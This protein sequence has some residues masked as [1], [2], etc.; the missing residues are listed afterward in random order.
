[1]PST[2]VRAADQKCA[3]CHA[4]IYH[5][6]LST[7]MANASGAAIDKLHAGAFLHKASGAQYQVAITGGAADLSYL[8]S[9]QPAHVDRR[10]LSYFLGSGHLGTTYLY[11]IGDYLFESP[12]AWYAASNSYDMKPGLAE[13]RQLPPPL[14]MQSSCLRCHMS[15][16]QPSDPGTMNRFSGPA[17]LH[18]GITCEA[19]HGDS[20]EHV[21]SHGKAAI[22]N[23]AHLDADRRDSV[24]ISCHLE[25]DV[26]VERAG[27][28]ALNYKPGEPISNYLAFYVRTGASLTA[29]GVSEVEQLSQSV[30]KRTSGDK[31]SC[32]SCHDPHFTPA[33]DQRVAFYRGKCLACHAEPGFATAHHPENQD[34][35]GCHM[36]RT[37]AANILHVAWTD[38]RILRVPTTPKPDAA[39]P[40]AARPGTATQDNVHLE[41]IFSPSANQRDLALASYQL[42]L[43][44]DRA[45]EPD[46]YNQLKAQ[47]GSISSDAP[48]LDAWG[49]L[50]AERGDGQA[51]EQAFRRVLELQPNDLTALS[52][53]GILLAKQGKL[54]EAIPLL[55][56]AFARNED[57]PGLA[58]N[59]A[60]IECMA[61]DGA[62]GQKTLNT[63]L[64]YAP[65]LD[66]LRKLLPQMTACSAGAR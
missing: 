47:L 43:E 8:D 31:M 1:M 40:G 60:R 57:V 51:A 61:G 32:T 30:C 23:P 55:E 24:C 53:L 65:G 10:T 49:N 29:R 28:S 42:L 34:C 59:L 62:A 11:S 13:M 36:P 44:G 2:P 3:Q 50:C 39:R 5:R 14:P 56:R 20:A 46:A 64:I 45:F 21:A 15:A 7:P 58:M 38:H 27:H 25:G 17:F 48:A 9:A 35:T 41:P 63:A 16:V 37:G 19:C 33:S 6:Y 52:N 54:K 18:G 66:D 26:S 12:I 4:E 22:V